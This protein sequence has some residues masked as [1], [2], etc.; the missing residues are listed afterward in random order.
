MSPLDLCQEGGS[1]QDLL[2]QSNALSGTELS[3]SQTKFAEEPHSPETQKEGDRK[4]LV[5][6][7][8]EKK[9]TSGEGRME[10]VPEEPISIPSRQ[11]SAT[12]SRRS[13]TGVPEFDE[14]KWA[15]PSS[16]HPSRLPASK[17]PPLLSHDS[18]KQGL[19]VLKKAFKLMGKKKKVE[20]EDEPAM[21]SAVGFFSSQA[22]ML[23]A[24]VVGKGCHG[25]NFV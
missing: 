8:D 19:G 14:E 24:A 22:T 3:K 18:R 17:S 11:P 6:E 25:Y 16:S 2:L 21:A 5:E 12:P 7:A 23:V 1:L 20:R 15:G 9:E 4:K 13:F 10:V